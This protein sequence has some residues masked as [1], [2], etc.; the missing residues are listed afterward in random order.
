MFHCIFLTECIYASAVLTH[1]HTGQLSGVP[2]THGP[3]V[4][5]C[6]LCTACF[7]CLNI[8]FLGSTYTINICL[9]L[10]TIYIFIPVSG[11]VGRGPN[12]LLCPGAYDTVKT[13]LVC[14]MLFIV[15][16]QF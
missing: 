6:M 16:Y 10:M 12:G 9:I 13:A 3:E 5:I 2:R 1:G 8:D 15:I 11:C 4:N 7:L 14:T